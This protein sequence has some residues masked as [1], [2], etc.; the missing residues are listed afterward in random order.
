MRLANVVEVTGNK[1]TPKE[2]SDLELQIWKVPQVSAL[3][4]ISTCYRL[5]VGE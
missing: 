1:F 5:L 4:I 3:S 2:V